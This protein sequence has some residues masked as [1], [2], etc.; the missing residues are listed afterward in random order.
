MEKTEPFVA[1]VIYPTTPDGQSRWAETLAKAARSELQLL[2]G[3]LHAQVLVSEDGQ[4]L[5]TMTTWSDRESF[6]Q[7][8]NSDYGRM[9]ALVASAAMPK[10][11]WLRL[12]AEIAAP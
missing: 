4:S 7:F 3:F 1:L 5:V 8:R 9:A 12:H 11:F 6:E 10:P 2:P